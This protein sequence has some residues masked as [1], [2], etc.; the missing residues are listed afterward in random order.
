MATDDEAVLVI[1][2]GSAVLKAGFAD[3]Y[4]PRVTFP[5]IIG[6]PHIQVFIFG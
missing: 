1:D 6:R 4:S 2:N 5:S 3:D